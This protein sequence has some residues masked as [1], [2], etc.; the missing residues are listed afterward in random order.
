[1]FSER[2]ANPDCAAAFDFR[3]GHIFRFHLDNGRG[4]ERLNVHAV[5]H[6]WLCSDCCREY[7]LEFREGEAILLKCD[8]GVFCAVGSAPLALAG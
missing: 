7:T 4:S 2:C 1:M 8:P 6:F 3:R 5:R